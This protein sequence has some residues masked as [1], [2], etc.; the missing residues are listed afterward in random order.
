[1]RTIRNRGMMNYTVLIMVL[2]AVVL[3]FER[4]E[5]EI[6]ED[7]YTTSEGLLI[8]QYLKMKSDTFGEFYKILEKTKSVSFL[9]AYGQ[10][11]CF[12]PNNKAML[13][14]YA[15]L[16]KSN[17]DDF[18][19]EADIE[20]L[21]NIIKY[22]ICPDSIST[23]MFTDGGLPDTTM[24]GDILVT[25]FGDGGVYSIKVN[26]EAN[27]F[28]WDISLINGVVHGIDK[29]LEPVLLSV[30][31]LIVQDP[32]YTI[33][34]KALIETGLYD[35]INNKS[36]KYTVFAEPD[37]ILNLKGIMDYEDLLATYSQ[38]GE[39]YQNTEDTLYLWIAYHI[40]DFSY[41]LT[42]LENKTYQNLTRNLLFTVQ[43][44]VQFLVNSSPINT[45]KS[46]IAAKNGT[47]HALDDLLSFIPVP[48][49]VY[50]EFTDKPEIKALTNFYR[51]K[52]ISPIP[53]PDLPDGVAGISVAPGD[54][55]KYGTGD[56]RYYNNDFIEYKFEAA[57]NRLWIEFDLPALV[58]GGEYKIWVCAKC[59]DGNRSPSVD[60]YWDDNFMKNISFSKQYSGTDE[61]LET[62]GIKLYTEP[63][64]AQMV[65]QLIGTI[66]V[67]DNRPHKIKFV[68]GA[69]GFG[70]IDMVHIIPVDDNQVSKKFDMWK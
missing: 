66:K 49:P 53:G 27:M 9:N 45:R 37:S 60:V 30:A 1:M 24:S 31:E 4:C 33:F 69:D 2:A 39:P 11:T 59:V 29:V 50:F 48:V 41:F 65:G 12:V 55:Y 57:T 25:S 46:N 16:G 61:E 70:T 18:T 22:H 15:L 10:Y 6:P 51:K 64:N 8:G 7:A 26:H 13:D 52:S 5:K 34:G 40:T 62:L 43:E 21:R 44:G 19:T 63:R 3:V 42:D 58:E 68:R 67:E 14:Y 23:G 38:T 28:L 35:T 54:F 56:K 36:L 32:D 20:N 17:V 47:Y